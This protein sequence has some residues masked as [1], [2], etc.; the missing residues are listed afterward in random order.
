MDESQIAS[1]SAVCNLIVSPNKPE[2]SDAYD[3][4]RSR[5]MNLSK[6]TLL[7]I[8]FDPNSS[9]LR[10]A[11]DAPPLIREAFHCDSSNSSTE[12]GIE[13]SAVSVYRRKIFDSYQRM[14][15]G[16]P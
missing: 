3:P 15:S 9:Y 16:V 11:A 13:P 8:P 2:Y 7:G 12:S 1:D 10:G 14:P 5:Q 4:I 6:P